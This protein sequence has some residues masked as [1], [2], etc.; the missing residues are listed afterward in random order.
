ME[1]KRKSDRVR[2]N[3]NAILLRLRSAQLYP[4]IRII[5]M[6][7]LYQ[8]TLCKVLQCSSVLLT[9]LYDDL[10]LV[11]AM[12]RIVVGHKIMRKLVTVR[13]EPTIQSCEL[14]FLSLASVAMQGNEPSEV[15]EQTTIHVERHR[16]RLLVEEDVYRRRVDAED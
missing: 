4:Y 6:P 3:N 14:P 2:D 8:K 12:S 1:G 10:L 13:A 5:N 15:E 7:R 9:I 11:P 16:V